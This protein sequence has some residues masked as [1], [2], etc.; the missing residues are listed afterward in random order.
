VAPAGGVERWGRLVF[1]AGCAILEQKR[2]AVSMLE[3]RF[4]VDFDEACRVL[5]ELQ[6]AGLI[7]PYMGGRTRDILLTREEWLAHAPH[8]PGTL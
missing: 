5:D 4:G 6:E 3:R 7:G 1:D 2:V 8:A